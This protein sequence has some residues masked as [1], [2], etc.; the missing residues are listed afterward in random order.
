MEVVGHQ[1]KLVEEK[2]FVISVVE[3]DI[4]EESSHSLGLK[5]RAPLVRRR[6]HEERPQGGRA[7][8]FRH[9][10]DSGAKEFV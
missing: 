8:R 7:R 1:Y 5:Q 3:Q 10:I 6:S 4:D 9:D 2:T